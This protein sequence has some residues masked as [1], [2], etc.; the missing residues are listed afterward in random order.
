MPILAVT[1]QEGV[2]TEDTWEHNPR[3]DWSKRT[4]DDIRE[5]R[6]KRVKLWVAEEDDQDLQHPVQADDHDTGEPGGTEPALGA[7]ATTPA[8]ALN[9]GEAGPTGDGVPVGAEISQQGGT[10]SVPTQNQSQQQRELASQDDETPAPSAAATT[11]PVS[12]GETGP[13]GDG[14]PVGAEI[15]HHVVS[16]QE[17]TSLHVPSAT[18]TAALATVAMATLPWTRPG[19]A[20]KGADGQELVQVQGQYTDKGEGEAAFRPAALATVA[21]A[22]LPWTR[23]GAAGVKAADPE[24]CSNLEDAK[25]ATTTTTTDNVLQDVIDPQEETGG[26]EEVD[27]LPEGQRQLQHCV[28]PEDTGRTQ[29]L[30][31]GSLASP[32]P[33]GTVGRTTPR[34]P[35]RAPPPTQ[36]GPSRAQQDKE[37]EPGRTGRTAGSREQAKGEAHQLKGKGTCCCTTPN[38]TTEAHRPKKARDETCVLPCS[39]KAAKVH[40]GLAL[41]SERCPPQHSKV[42]LGQRTGGGEETGEE[43]T[44]GLLGPGTE[45]QDM[46]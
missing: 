36:Q 20:V 4:M 24:P 26:D 35:P 11:T 18:T 27:V 13:T 25:V 37:W 29:M 6:V 15:S 19:A 8:S 33:R 14:V 10:G 45:E 22:T 32:Q 7:A 43:R 23:P 28:D 31:L 2:R 39:L 21:M 16:N 12:M 17:P 42:R 1:G 9:Q 3:K 38:P 44:C 40:D 5:G 34:H 30:L 46:I 41:A